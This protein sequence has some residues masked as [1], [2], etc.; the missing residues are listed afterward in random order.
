MEV[1]ARELLSY[2]QNVPR[3]PRTATTLPARAKPVSAVT[4]IL[5][6]QAQRPPKQ[7]SEDRQ[8]DQQAGGQPIEHPCRRQ[9]PDA[10]EPG[11]KV[12]EEKRRDSKCD[13]P[14]ASNLDHLRQGPA[15]SASYE[16]FRSAGA[17]SAYRK[18]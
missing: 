14:I 16:C 10:G 9:N 8:G 15:I 4:I 7:D 18:Y 5:L 2:Q 1:S 13:E 3:L 17:R 6:V 12:A 11:R